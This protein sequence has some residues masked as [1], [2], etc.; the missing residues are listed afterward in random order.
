MLDV[1]RLDTEERTIAMLFANYDAASAYD[2][3]FAKTGGPRRGTELLYD[4]LGKLT[5][6][7]LQHYQNTAMATMRSLGITF[8]V[9]GHADGTEKI[10]PLDVIPRVIENAEWRMVER[11]LKQRAIALNLFVGDIYNEQKCIRDT[12]GKGTPYPP[13]PSLSCRDASGSINSRNAG[14]VG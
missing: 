3:M 11:G 13:P 5:G 6:N 10:W 12:S 9:Y 4:R 14:Y 7:E 2:E 8:N 1:P